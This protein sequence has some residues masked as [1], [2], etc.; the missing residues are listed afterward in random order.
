MKGLILET[1]II[2]LRSKNHILE[3]SKYS[4]KSALTYR[5]HCIQ[6][7]QVRCDLP[8]RTGPLVAEPA[9]GGA[10]RSRHGLPPAS[11]ANADEST[12]LLISPYFSSVTVLK[13]AR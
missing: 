11:S 4:P 10:L 8:R 9:L 2:N 5:V 6:S 7:R 12:D 1:I 13:E 3:F